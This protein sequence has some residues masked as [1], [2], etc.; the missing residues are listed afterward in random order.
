MII[1]K[2]SVDREITS[3]IASFYELRYIIIRRLDHE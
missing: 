1:M 2:S 3:V